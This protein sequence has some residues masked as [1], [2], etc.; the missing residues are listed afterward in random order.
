M[1]KKLVQL[2]LIGIIVACAIVFDVS[3]HL[4]HRL[5]VNH[6]MGSST[7][8]L[9]QD[10]PT[11]DTSESPQPSESP[12]ST[13]DASTTEE[14]T[15]KEEEV[16]IEDV[17]FQGKTLF[18]IKRKLGEISP[19]VRAQDISEKIDEIAKDYTISLDDLRLVDLES[20]K[21]I[22]AG[23]QMIMALSEADAKAANKSLD[24]LADEYRVI[25]QDAIQA[26]RTSMTREEIFWGGVRAV[27]STIGFL[28]GLVIIN[29]TLPDLFNKISNWQ[30]QRLSSIRYQGL[31][32]L[33]RYQVSAF[34]ETSFKIIRFL[35]LFILFY[36]YVPFL[37]TC[38]ALTRPIGKRLQSYFW[39]AVK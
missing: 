27:V 11:P 17:T 24:K 23:D 32:F 1:M 26:F 20:L 5:P 33:S 28:I 14:N 7:V 34:L 29:R 18:T 4:I 25:I 8:I 13:E 2:C 3:N 6:F 9:A 22:Q 38:F 30:Q 31:Q 21:L 10:S 16:E 19:E 36:F 15:K 37:L 12:I 35:L 39:Q